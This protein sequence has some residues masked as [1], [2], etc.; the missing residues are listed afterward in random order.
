MLETLLY[1]PKKLNIRQVESRKASALLLACRYRKKD[2]VRSLLSS[3]AAIDLTDDNGLGVLHCT[4]GKAEILNESLEGEIVDIL[5]L[6]VEYKARVSTGD[7]SELKQQPLHYCAMTGK[8]LAAEYILSV[9]PDVINLADGNGKTALY[10]ACEHL[11]PKEKLV[12][13]LLKKNATFGEKNRPNL[14]NVR[15]QRI[16][17]M[18]DNVQQRGKRLTD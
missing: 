11:S 7:E 17:K 18:L 8:C 14:H 12:K 15:H 1:R 6:L 10:H 5:R 9:D 13:L 2:I 3:D 16:C 4:I